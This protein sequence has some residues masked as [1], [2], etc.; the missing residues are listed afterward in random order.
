M[1]QL[2]VKSFTH[3]KDRPNADQALAMLQRVASLV[4]P[5]MRKHGWILP[6]LSEFFPESPNLLDVNG[7]EKILLRLRPAWAPDTFYDLEDVVH[8]MLHELSHNVHGPHDEKFYKF[9]SG[10]EEEYDALKRSGY[11]G[12][13]FFSPGHRVGTGVSHD[14]P[15][16]IAR[17][18]ALEAAERRR[19]LGTLMSGGRRLGGAPVRRNLSPRELAAEAA[20]RRAR[21]EKACGSGVLAQWEAQKAAKESV[22][23]EA[24]DLTGDASDGDSDVIILDQPPSEPLSAKVVVQQSKG[25]ALATSMK[26]DSKHSKRTPNAQ[27]SAVPS[28]SGAVPIVDGVWSCPA[29]TYFNA[30]AAFRC[31]MCDTSRPQFGSSEGWTCRICGEMGM[32]QEFWTCRFCGTMKP[33]S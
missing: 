17:Q 11:A 28:G 12:E 13:G 4:K 19:K 23:S 29:C 24:I 32:H 26:S 30:A 18:K 22:E 7:G 8:T 9:L 27:Q 25:K 3:L 20:E 6:V 2:Y 33:S 31:A 15:P 1:A 16:H 14:L 5:I 10:L 21:D